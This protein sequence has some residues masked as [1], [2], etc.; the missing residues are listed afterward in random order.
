MPRSAAAIFP[1][2]MLAALGAC[3]GTKPGAYVDADYTAMRDVPAVLRGTIGSRGSLGGAEPVLCSGFGVVV[4]LNGTGGGIIPE[5]IAGHMER[6]L[7]LMG[8]GDE[9]VI[10]PGSALWNTPENRPKTPSELLR[11]PDVAVVLVRAAIPPGAPKDAEFDVEVT[12]LATS[13]TTSLEGGQLWTTRLQLGQASITGGM[14]TRVIAEAKGPLFINPFQDPV[15]APTE[16]RRAARVLNGGIITDPLELGLVLD[17]ESHTTARYVTS[18]INSRFPPGP[19]DDG[20]TA[21]GLGGRGTAASRSMTIA[22]RVPGAYRDKPAEFVRIVEYLQIDPAFPQE[23]A[24]RY[25]RGLKEQPFLADELS[26]ALEAIGKPALPFIRELYDYPEQAPRLAALRAGAHLGDPLAAP[27][28]IDL[29]LEDDPSRAE[30]ITLLADL[31]GGPTVDLTLRDLAAS[32]QLDVRIAAYESLAKRAE[33]DELERILARDQS[34]P[35]GGPA[36]RFKEYTRLAGLRFTGSNMQGIRRRPVVDADANEVKFVVDIVPYGDPMI[37]CTLQRQ[38][39]IA[40]FGDDLTLER[41]LFASAWNDRFMLVADSPEQDIRLFY[42]DPRTNETTVTSADD[43]IVRLIQFLAF[44]PG[45]G[46]DA[47]GLDFSYSEVVGALSAI[48]ECGG[49]DAVFASE[50]D[51]LF[52]NLVAAQKTRTVTDRPESEGDPEVEYELP[53]I[54]AQSDTQG[55]RERKSLVVPIERTTDNG[56]GS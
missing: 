40:L 44:Q 7:A 18:A 6:E 17:T 56:S 32:E 5:A 21:R 20:P 22:L 26:W 3:S 30:A 37:Y 41:P 33:R 45:P 29:A 27:P 9:N 48:Q 19:G 51:R 16:T 4:G 43:E 35:G 1:I 36:D 46:Y 14:Q 38:P 25:V 2:A 47:P 12:A 31:D 34:M 8:V 54:V 10:D 49:I 42:R 50:Q 13:A 15:A 24:R 23:Y 28:L 53:P 55:P 11:D 52:A 39:R